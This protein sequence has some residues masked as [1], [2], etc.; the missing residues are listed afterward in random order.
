MAI[1]EL[2][3]K[4]DGKADDLQFDLSMIAPAGPIELVFLARKTVGYLYWQPKPAASLICSLLKATQDQ[5][6]IAHIAKLTFDALLTNASSEV[7]DLLCAQVATLPEA[8]KAALQHAMDTHEAYAADLR[9]TELLEVRASLAEQ[10]YHTN[11]M[12]EA[13][14]KAYR[15][16]MEQSIVSVLCRQQVILYGRSSA[17]MVRV[18]DEEQRSAMTLQSHGHSFTMPRM[19]SIDEV[20]VDYMRLVFR[21]E[22]I[23]E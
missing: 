4:M 15:Q 6:A 7:L 8:G 17:Q 11:R 5:T 21:N 13:M 19:P 12:A 3:E 9:S 16:A 23:R 14:G 22:T 10:E 18:G 1:C 2:I 20:G